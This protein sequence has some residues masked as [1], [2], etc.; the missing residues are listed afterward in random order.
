MPEPLTFSTLRAADVLAI[1]AQPSQRMTRQMEGELDFDAAAQLASE[2]IAWSARR[3]GQLIACFG[4]YEKIP[5]LRGIAWCI[6]AEGI[7]AS[8]LELTRFLR[9][10]IEGCQLRRVELYAVANSVE[11]ELA[12][13]PDLDA[14]QVVAIAMS[15]PS[16][17]CRWAQMLGLRPAHL[18]RHFGEDGRSE[19]MFE[20]IRP[21]A[22]LDREEA[23]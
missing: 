10:Q 16:P 14:G 5:G 9:S 18:L 15:K 4:I 11:V 7:G 17:E 20:R 6:L 12:S 3:G 8:H 23:A 22:L 1:E 19:M 2:T 13:L 21:L